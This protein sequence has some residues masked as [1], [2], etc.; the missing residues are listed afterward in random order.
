MPNFCL[1]KKRTMSHISNFKKKSEKCF[2]TSRIMNIYSAL[3]R[4]KTKKATALIIWRNSADRC[5][6]RRWNLR[7]WGLGNYPQQAKYEILCRAGFF[8]FVRLYIQRQCLQKNVWLN[9]IYVCYPKCQHPGQI[10][11][12]RYNEKQLF[13]NSGGSI[14]EI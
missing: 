9:I 14:N 6:A 5:V 4:I 11:R 7:S 1:R 8:Y 3:S 13:M 12:I 10:F 2:C